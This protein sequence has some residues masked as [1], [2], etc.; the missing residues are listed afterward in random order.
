MP[1]SSL[2]GCLG[3][4]RLVRQNRRLRGAETQSTPDLVSIRRQSVAE[5]LHLVVGKATVLQAGRTAHERVGRVDAAATAKNGR[6]IHAG[7][8]DV[9]E[10]SN[11]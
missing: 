6:Q 4:Y 1:V 3:I 9:I 5:L 2:D 10:L 7:R 11:C 8:R